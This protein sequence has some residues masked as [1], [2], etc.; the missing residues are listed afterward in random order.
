MKRRFFYC[1]AFAITVTAWAGPPAIIRNGDFS[2][3]L[4]DNSKLPSE[5]RIDGMA[6]EIALDT[7]KTK[8]SQASLRVAYKAGA[9]YAG[10]IQTVPPEAV[11]GKR[12]TLRAQ[13]ARRGEKA[14][15][16]IWVGIFD[17]DK[18][19]L[20]YR[21]SYETVQAADES[22]V[23]HVVEIDVP[24]NAERLLI[25]SAIYEADGVMWVDTMSVEVR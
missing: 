9:P 17:K 20:A 24:E 19:R 23:P 15:V 18:K 10:V 2:A 8:S 11:R 7:A 25:G 6:T 5:W 3:T 1:V 16:G 13:I 21:N 14:V 4:A 12:L 22:W